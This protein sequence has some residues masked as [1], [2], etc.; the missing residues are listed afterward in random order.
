MIRHL[1]ISCAIAFGIGIACFVCFIIGM[2]HAPQELPSD[3]M[4]MV[5]GICDLS[6]KEPWKQEIKTS[7]GFIQ[8]YLAIDYKC[9]EIRGCYTIR[10]SNGEIR[11]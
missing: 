11:Y 5:Q 2:S 1:V 4:D 8:D 6:R 7:C 9:E 10:K 3:E